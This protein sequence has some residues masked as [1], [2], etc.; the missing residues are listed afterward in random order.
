MNNS[1]CGDSSNTSRR[2]SR[3]N[4]NSGSNRHHTDDDD[5]LSQSTVSTKP[6]EEEEETNE[7]LEVYGYEEAAP[8]IYTH[9]HPRAQRHSSMPMMTA[10]PRRSSMKQSGSTTR[11]RN[12]ITYRG[13]NEVR[14]PGQLFVHRR[15]SLGFSDEDSV[16]YIE[17]A[18]NLVDN[19]EEL[20][21]QQHEID[22]I[23]EKAATLIKEAQEGEIEVYARKHCLRGLERRLDET[24]FKIKKNQAMDSVL[25]AQRYVKG[26][27]LAQRYKTTTARSQKD[28]QLRANADEKA[29]EEYLRAERMRLRRLTM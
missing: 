22:H 21:F 28:A 23:R 11:R 1:S 8:D 24:I 3:K 16:S 6:E 15:T 14:L 29:V 20:W 12:S 7:R 25:S 13:E 4:S 18:Q 17:P 2:C 5:A 26:E 19:P 10:T 9:H 27:D